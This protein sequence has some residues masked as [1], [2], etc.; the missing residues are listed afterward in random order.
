MHRVAIHVPQDWVHIDLSP[1]GDAKLGQALERLVAAGAVVDDSDAAEARRSLRR[2]RNAARKQNAV[3]AAVWARP[4][5]EHLALAASLLVAIRPYWRPPGESSEP[6]SDPLGP[7]VTSLQDAPDLT[8]L[9]RVELPGGNAV[10]AVRRH[11]GKRNGD[12]GSITVQYYIPVVGDRPEGDAGPD[13]EPTSPG[14]PWSP[15]T[16]SA[17]VVAGFTTPVSPL[18]DRFLELFG[19]LAATLRVDITAR[20]PNPEPDS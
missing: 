12:P 2:V 13:G 10:R 8:E 5:A 7:I 14:V 15:R 11:H 19:R 17:V 3:I 1:Q 20:Q 6:V 16:P 9:E 18:V 4:H